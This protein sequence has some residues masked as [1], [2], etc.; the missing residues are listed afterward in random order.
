[1]ETSEN[2]GLVLQETTFSNIKRKAKLQLWLYK[3]YGRKT[4]DLVNVFICSDK[5]KAHIPLNDSET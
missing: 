4:Q 1:M 5:G 2:I 3:F